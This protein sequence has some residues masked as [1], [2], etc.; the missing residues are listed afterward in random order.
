M[1]AD[2]KRV[3]VWVVRC[4]EAGAPMIFTDA[5]SAYDE[6]EALREGCDDVTVET[7]DTMTQEE[8]DALPEHPGWY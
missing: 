7:D 2:E 4:P 3:R 1:M 8:I 5:Y 6:A